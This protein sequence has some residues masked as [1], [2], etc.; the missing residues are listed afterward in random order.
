MTN[1]RSPW[2]PRTVRVLRAAV[3]AGLAALLCALPTA[4]QPVPD[5]AATE[6]A[7]PVRID[8]PIQEHVLANGLRVVLVPDNTAPTV[9]VVLYYDVGSRD[10]DPGRSGFAHLFEHMMFQGSAN[11][12]KGQHFV[13]IA[14]NGGEMNGTT[15]EDRTNYFQTVPSDRLDLALWLESDR[16]MSLDVSQENL[17]NQRV[18]VQEERRQRYDN[19]P[20]RIAWMNFFDAIGESWPYQHSTIGS[21]EDLNAATLDDVRA[22]FDL[23]YK[24]NNAVLVLAG[25]IESQDALA[26]VNRWFGEIPAG[27]LPPRPDVRD[28]RFSQPIVMETT[29]PLASRPMVTLAWRVPSAPDPQ[30]DVSTL[31]GQLLANGQSSRLYSRMV[32]QDA[33][34]LS[35]SAGSRGRRAED[36]FT[37]YA[38]GT[39]PDPAVLQQTLLEEI[40]RLAQDGPTEEELEAARRALTR[41]VV[42]TTETNQGRALS[43]GRDVL[44]YG[45]P[46]RGLQ[47][48]TRWATISPQDV[49]TYVQTWLTPENMATLIVRPAPAQDQEAAE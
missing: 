38:L 12:G 46:H 6:T 24:P 35:V 37:V 31:L 41:Q 26:R 25:D 13:Y 7:A 47:A 48:P 29:D 16:M 42:Q 49:Q 15:S 11:V 9:A 23:H 17:D 30:A 45:D 10:E 2:P 28:V 27:E 18:V 14:R 33:S 8:L 20:Y 5:A 3:G 1:T 40:S 34:A 21:M 32:R 22:F 36:V 19:V 43:I 4:A 39:G 44:Y